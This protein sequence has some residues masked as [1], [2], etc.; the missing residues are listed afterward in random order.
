MQKKLARWKWRRTVAGNYIDYLE[1]NRSKEYA[2][3][4]MSRIGVFF[5]WL[6]TTAHKNKIITTKTILEFYDYL[7]TERGVSDATIVNYHR[8]LSTGFKWIHERHYIQAN[9]MKKVPK[10]KERNVVKE[11]FTPAEMSRILLAIKQKGYEP[12]RNTA[13][14]LMAYGC[15]LRSGGIRSAKMK[16]LDMETRTLI[17]TEKGNKQ[18]KIGLGE[19]VREA[20]ELHLA[21]RPDSPY[22]FVNRRGKAMG[23]NLPNKMLHDACKLAGVRPRKFHLLRASWACQALKSMDARMVQLALGH[24]DFETT[25]IYI[26]TA[27]DDEVANQMRLHSPADNL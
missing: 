17:I 6:E 7:R 12:Y 21:T 22:L 3:S 4:S 14:V 15:G 11:P 9:P 20:L 5:D 27:E 18:R 24:E 8:H 19:R 1:R 13:I 23:D 2:R 25:R 26:K 10:P 16:D